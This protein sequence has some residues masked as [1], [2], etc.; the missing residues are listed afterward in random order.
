[1]VGQF[2]WVPVAVKCEKESFKVRYE[3]EGLGGTHS[4][5][6]RKSG[7]AIGAQ[8]LGHSHSGTAAGAQPLGHSHWGTAAGAQ[9]LRHSRWGTA[10]RAQLLGHSHWGTACL[11]VLSLAGSLQLPD[12]EV[13]F[14]EYIQLSP[15]LSFT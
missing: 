8:P 5:C 9:P 15:F 14:S 6:G 3:V 10:I 7:P 1:M 12:R 13:V 11:W 4:L 2:L